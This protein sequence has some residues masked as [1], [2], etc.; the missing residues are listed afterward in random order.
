MSS[1]RGKTALVTGATKRLGR[2]IVLALADEGVNVVVHYRQSVDEARSLCQE[3]ERRGVKAWQLDADFEDSGRLEQVFSQAVDLAGSLDLLVNNASL[4]LPSTLQDVDWA[5]LM[6]HVQ[7][8]AWAPF[9]LAREFARQVGR[10]R[11]VNL[12]DSRVAGNDRRHVAYILSKYLLAVLTEMM[13]REFAPGVTV[14]GVAPGLILPP[15]GQ[16]KSYLDKLAKAL[17]LQCH[18]EPRDIADAV[19]YLL[20]S[21]FVTGQIIFVDGGQHLR[22]PSHGPDHHH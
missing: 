4:F 14:N 7:I 19:L 12:L 18:G 10:G 6:R 9:V 15:A 22:E 17:P 16:E 5:G 1:L 8:N 21:D 13:A 3:L 20:K 11:I 2:A